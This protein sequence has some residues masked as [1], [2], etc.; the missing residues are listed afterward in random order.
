MLDNELYLALVEAIQDAEN[1]NFKKIETDE[2]LHLEE[3]KKEESVQLTE[4]S[5]NFSVNGYYVEKE[6]RNIYKN[7]KLHLQ[8]FKQEKSLAVVI[9]DIC[10]EN[11]ISLSEVVKKA[12]DDISKGTIYRLA[13]LFQPTKADKKT[14][15]LMCFYLNT[16]VSQA[17]RLLNAGGFL[18]AKNSVFDMIALKCI[19][20]GYSMDTLKQLIDLYVFENSSLQERVA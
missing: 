4:V 6:V 20:E 12:R 9:N 13:N 3:C 8:Q 10:S 1:S 15:L 19:E 17:H 18:F 16:N 14:L 5:S 11:N 7:M 2:T